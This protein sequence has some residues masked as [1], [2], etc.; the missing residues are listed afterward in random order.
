[1]EGN[2]VSQIK[3]CFQYA[4]ESFT[5]MRSTSKA[6]EGVTL[7]QFLQQQ[8]NAS[9]TANMSLNPW[10]YAMDLP[11]DFVEQACFLPRIAPAFFRL[12]ST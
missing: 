2:N 9:G 7:G 10:D 11:E 8:Q 1:M 3:R 6:I 4:M 5:E 12:S